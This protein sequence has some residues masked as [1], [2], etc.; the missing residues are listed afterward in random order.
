MLL[1]RTGFADI[2]SCELVE[3]LSMDYLYQAFR[4]LLAFPVV[5]FSHV[6]PQLV[7]ERAPF[8]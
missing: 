8:A 6:H 3:S 1:R 5:E 7:E 2:L 4:D